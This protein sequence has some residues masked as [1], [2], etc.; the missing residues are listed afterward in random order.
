MYSEMVLAEHEAF[1][2][3][4]DFIHRYFTSINLYPKDELNQKQKYMMLVR[5]MIIFLGANFDV[6]F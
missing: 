1:C 2:I 3:K 6:L 4:Q 5:E